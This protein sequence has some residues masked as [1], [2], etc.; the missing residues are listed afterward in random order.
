LEQREAAAPQVSR[1]T[2]RRDP[3][4]SRRLTR[5][6]DLVSS[7][8]ILVIALRTAA[9]RRVLR[10]SQKTEPCG[11]IVLTIAGAIA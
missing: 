3:T 9:V 2:N 10:P 5:D 11:K 4:G 7:K 8:S 6:G 1:V